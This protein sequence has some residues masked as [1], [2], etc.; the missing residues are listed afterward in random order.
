MDISIAEE[1]VD[2]AF[3]LGLKR[4]RTDALFRIRLAVLV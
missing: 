4:Y 3:R 1:L 2:L